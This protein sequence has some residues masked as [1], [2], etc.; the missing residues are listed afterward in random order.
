MGD[1]REGSETSVGA[2][3]PQIFHL[4]AALGNVI[5]P[6]EYTPYLEEDDTPISVPSLSELLYSSSEEEAHG[7]AARWRS[8]TSTSEQYAHTSESEGSSDE[9]SKSA[10]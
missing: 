3:L 5:N 1:L 10:S 8:S 2:V 4:A 7:P 6:L 9:Q